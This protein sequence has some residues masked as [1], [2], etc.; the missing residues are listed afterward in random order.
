[1]AAT[2]KKPAGRKRAKPKYTPEQV[3]A[4]RAEQRE[5]GAELF[6]TALADLQTSE[7]WKRWALV[8][9]RLYSYSFANTMLILAQMPEARMVASA[10]FWHDQKRHP[11]AGSRAL[12]VFAPLLRNPTAE[13][14]AAGRAPGDKV[15][16]AFK[17]VPVFDV[18][19][20]DGEPLPVIRAEP[21]TGST[22]A[23]FIPRLEKL[24]LHTGFS[25]SYEDLSKGL[26]GYCD[27][28]AKH[29]AIN[30]SAA[31]NAQVSVLVHEIAHAMGVGYEE[32]G[33]EQA[34][35][36][37]ETAAFIVCT[38]I[39]LDTSQAS[40]PYVAGWGGADA[41]PALE[42]FA[43]VVDDVARRIEKAIAP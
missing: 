21:V 15:L 8:R 26:E 40:V 41:L 24:A 4:Y 20:T 6:K 22:H 32:Y 27:P 18:S 12:R 38:S 16:I 23:S 7:G 33:R 28:K 5:K 30:R 31:P 25:V 43:V 39:G 42:R 36:L 1:M 9:A 29:I 11:V 3:A 34:E 19:Q 35:V 2:E 37:V 17:L 10:K 13:E 14:L